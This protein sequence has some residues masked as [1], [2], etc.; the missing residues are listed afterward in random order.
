MWHYSDNIFHLV[1]HGVLLGWAWN[2]KTLEVVLR[3]A[4]KNKPCC[5]LPPNQ[6]LHPP[7]LANTSPPSFQPF[8]P[9][10]LFT[11]LTQFNNPLTYPHP[12]PTNLLNHHHH[13]IMSHMSMYVNPLPD[14]KSAEQRQIKV[15]SGEVRLMCNKSFSVRLIILRFYCRKMDVCAQQ[16]LG[17]RLP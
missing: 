4:K 17:Q 5:P 15:G 2:W 12:H 6:H 10:P 14:D 8:P 1:P 7:A 13:K 3:D 16:N 9:P 11:S